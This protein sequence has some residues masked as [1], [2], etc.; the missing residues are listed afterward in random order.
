METKRFRI[1]AINPQAWYEVGIYTARS[2]KEAVEKARKDFTDIR[3]FEGLKL[4]VEE[5]TQ[6]RG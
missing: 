6:A 4:I 5:I 2:E 3:V 1:R